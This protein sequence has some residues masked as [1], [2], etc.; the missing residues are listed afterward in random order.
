MAF[1][2]YLPPRLDKAAIFLVQCK[3]FFT[4]GQDQAITTIDPREP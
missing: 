3:G 2:L 4:P 1:F